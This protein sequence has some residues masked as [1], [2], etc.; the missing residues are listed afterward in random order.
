[1][2]S[3]AKPPLRPREIVLDGGY[4]GQHDKKAVQLLDERIDRIGQRRH[5]GRERLNHLDVPF[6]RVGGPV[7]SGHRVPELVIDLVG[8]AQRRA[9][10]Q[11]TQRSRDEIE[12]LAQS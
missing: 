7:D 4:R 8:L 2:P 11:R 9:A 12:R 1:M 5:R 3:P 6:H 10:Q